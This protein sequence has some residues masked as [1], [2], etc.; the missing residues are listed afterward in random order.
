MKYSI[1]NNKPSFETFEFKDNE[2]YFYY[3]DNSH[4]VGSEMCTM[5]G[6]EVC[7]M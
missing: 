3:Y 1:I 4:I 7:K 6:V 2:N 5:M